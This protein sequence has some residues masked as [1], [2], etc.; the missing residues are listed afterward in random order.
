MLPIYICDDDK[1]IVSLIEAV[2]KKKILIEDYDMEVS[3]CA[4]H[5]KNLLTHLENS[6]KKRNLF[7]LDVELKNDYFDGFLLGREIRKIDPYA[8]IVYVTSYG[9]LAYKTFTYHIEAFDY[10]VKDSGTL[11]DS[12]CK[13]LESVENKLRQETAQDAR[14][15]LLIKIGDSVKHFFTEDILYFETSSKA[16]HVLLYTCNGRYDFIGN[17]NELEAQL[18]GHFIR[19]H[20]SYLVA[21]DKIDEFDL[22]HNRL[23]IAGQ[24]CL[25]SRKMKSQILKLLRNI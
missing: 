1:E 12:I 15:T 8:I 11:T 14:Q 13:V 17:L 25:V 20:R 2:I 24:E 22:K 6:R 21:A 16:H 23:I 19:C 9:D 4:Q 18:P 5:P 7:F 10:I 3:C